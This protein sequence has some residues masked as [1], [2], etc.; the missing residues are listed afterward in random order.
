MPIVRV[1][2][3][4]YKLNGVEILRDI[5]FSIESGEY[6]AIVGP[7]GGGKTTLVNIILQLKRGWSG[8]IEL[9]GTPVSKFKDWKKIG[10]LPQRAIDIDHK[11]P[12]KV[13]EVVRL[14]NLD[15]FW[16]KDQQVQKTMENLG[17]YEFKDR[18]IGELSGGQKQRVMIAR[19]LVS[20]PKLLFL[21]EPN[22]G[23]DQKTQAEFYRLLSDLNRE[24]SLTIVFITHDIGAI[25]ESVTS[26][27]SVNRELIRS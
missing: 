14:G 17:I 16:K 7:N 22:S 25:E 5:N 10:F 8:E 23:V 1:K 20:N 26:L 21:D 6:V 4:N 18:L 27:F 15:S 24:N 19:A 9:F 11:F 12:I 2:N 13:S 3:L